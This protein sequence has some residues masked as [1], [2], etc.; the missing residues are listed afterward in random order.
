MLKER[1]ALSAFIR[2]APC[3]SV[4]LTYIVFFDFIQKHKKVL[5]FD[6]KFRKNLC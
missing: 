4:L 1:L 2:L 6:E 3:L 5:F